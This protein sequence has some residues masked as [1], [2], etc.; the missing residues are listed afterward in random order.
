MTTALN[1]I[2]QLKS[3]GVE[4]NSL[5]AD[6]RQVQRGDVFLALPGA[7]SDGRAHVAAALARGAVALLWESCDALAPP[8]SAV[9]TIAVDGL[10]ALCGELAH[11]VY[12]APSHKL[13]LIGVTGTNGKTTVSQCLAQAMSLAGRPC[14]V[15]GTLGSGFA[16]AWQDS[17]NTTPDALS[18]QRRL[19]DFVAAGAQACAMEV[20]S[21]G[22]EQGRVATL[23]F[24]VAV[25]TNLT[26]DHL[27]YHGDMQ[28]Y[29]AAKR[30]LF[31]LP[32]VA[33][34]VLNVDDAFGAGLGVSLAQSGL[35]RIGYS[36]GGS[37]AAESVDELIVAGDLHVGVDGVRFTARCGSQALAVAAPLLGR[38]NVSNLLAVL[39][40][41]Y[42]SGLDF[43]QAVQLLPQLRAPAGRMQAIDAEAGRPLLVVDYA[44]S[45]DALQQALT[46]LREVARARGGRLLCL[47]G[48]GGERDRGKRPLMGAVAESLADQVIVS[49][50]NP[51]GEVPE[52]I[53]AEVLKGMARV[54]L[55]EPDRRLA[56]GA[57][58]AAAAAADVVLIAGKGHENYQEVGAMR[59]PF[60]DA[61]EARVA[62]SAW[63]AA[64]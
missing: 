40:A 24:D 62:L 1:I 59:L 49:S 36:L 13:W 46:T 51:R 31:T 7:R 8:A 11:L 9:P 21:I 28:N 48:C 64:P 33:A 6:S 2:E 63:E 12:G 35:R 55:V 15:I 10:A 54:P 61:E 3:R 16:G 57:A 41:L 19:G 32:G 5:C 37:A 39:A 34:A 25:L 56:I 60:C 17:P 29:A 22:L 27:D 18:L 4:V 47:F 44:H 20:S 30:R 53:I 43:A 50:D 45:P 52:A 26:R 58:V 38:F 23:A 42:A 14:A